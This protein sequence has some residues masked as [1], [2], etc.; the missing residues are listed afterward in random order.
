MI[1]VIVAL[2]T[3]KGRIYN[4]DFLKVL[5]RLCKEQIT[6]FKYKVVLSLSEEEFPNKEADLSDDLLTFTELENFEILWSYK[7]TKALKNYFP[8]KRKYKDTPIIVIGDDTL[9]SK[10][11]VQRVMEEHI[12][13][14][15]KALGNKLFYWDDKYNNIPVLW[16][17]RL[18]PPN[19]MFNLSE[20]YFSNYFKSLENDIFYGICLKLN[21]TECKC[22]NIPELVEQKEFFGQEKKL[23][24]EYSKPENCAIKLYENFVKD[25]SELLEIIKQK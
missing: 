10:N 22:L 2:T 1:D 5:Y 13:D 9:Y 17:V 15:T 24:T 8:V 7:N 16:Q 23:N 20:D 6:D 12:K 21:H 4:K 14:P 3:W 19:C 18:F 25:H 11:L